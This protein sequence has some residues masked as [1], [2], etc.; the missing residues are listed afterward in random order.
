VDFRI[1]ERP[2][3]HQPSSTVSILVTLVNRSGFRFVR[4]NFERSS[5]VYTVEPP[6]YIPDGGSS[7]FC[8]ESAGFMTGAVGAVIYELEGQKGVCKFQFSAPF[9]GANTYE[10]SCP[11]GF[12]V[13]RLGGSSYAA[14]VT[15]TVR[16]TTRVPDEIARK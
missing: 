7:A 9:I 4:S 2:V 15:Y 14:E 12:F 11:D 16:R 8:I 10:Y 3:D 5:G 6:F 13:E 1:K